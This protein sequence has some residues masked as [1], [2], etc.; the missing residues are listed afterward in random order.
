MGSPVEPAASQQ[1]P[2]PSQDPDPQLTHTRVN[3]GSAASKAANGAAIFAAVASRFARSGVNLV[4]SGA[5][6]AADGVTRATSTVL[7]V[8]A[9]VGS[10]GLG[11]IQAAGGGFRDFFLKNQVGVVGGAGFAGRSSSAASMQANML[12][13]SQLLRPPPC[14]ISHV[15]QGPAPPTWP[16]QHTHY[17]HGPSCMPALLSSLPSPP[18][19]PIPRL[20]ALPPAPAPPLP[21][22][23]VD[24]AVAVVI[25]MAFTSLMEAFTK[26]FISPALGVGG[27][28]TRGEAG[29][30][31]GC[32]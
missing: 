4:T 3:S 26:S 21:C 8:A 1:P 15:P 18:L 6:L 13:C 12:Y 25:G 5:T 2:G 30:E 28:Q 7:G 32:G 22:Q 10:V 14:P 16:L 11:G 19:V 20:A 27:R 31:Q 29:G 24:L 9:D 23:V 17:H